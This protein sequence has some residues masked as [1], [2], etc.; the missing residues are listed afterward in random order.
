V[1]ALE[2]IG[3][4][5]LARIALAAMMAVTAAMVLH[6]TRGTAIWFDEWSWVLDR[7]GGGLGTLLEPHNG[8]FSLVPLLLYKALFATAGIDDYTP[9]RVMVVVGHLACGGLLYA[10]ARPRIGPFAA[11]LP[12]A[13]L[14]LL[15]PAWQN[16]LWP[17]Q[18]AW[19]ISLASG[20]GALLALD[21]DDRRGEIV[22]CVLLALA[23]ASS[24][25][26][27]AIAAG[28]LVE[29]VWRRRPAWVVAAPIAGYALWWIAYQD[30]DFFRHNVTV[31]P[32][33]AAEAAGGALA[34]VTGLSEARV[35][36]NGTLIDAGAALVWGR[37]LVLAAAAVLIWRLV[38]L[39]P[40]PVR[41][42]ALLAMAA[43]F[44]LLGGLQRA[45]IQSPDASRYLYVGA[46]FV[47]L[48]AVE[49][50]RG[51]RVGR[52]IAALAVVLTGLAV[53]SNVG[54]LRAGGRNLRAQADVT[55]ADL[56]ALV[57]ARDTVPP[58][59]HAAFIPGVPFVQIDAKEYFAAARELGSIA[60][61]PAELAAASEQGRLAA[62][63]ELANLGQL[64]PRPSSERPG[65][66]PPEVDATTGGT[67][68]T[69]AGCVLF[70]PAAATPAG[71]V[72]ELQV[73]VPTG[74]MLLTATGGRATV[75]L[76]RFAATFPRDP[77]ARLATGGSSVLR[78]GTDRATQPWHARLRP[79][80][81]VTVCGLRPGA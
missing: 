18:I 32:K 70:R 64:L 80:A 8:H 48:I 5:T 78:P 26:G 62:D 47:L 69:E 9:Y 36:V 61:S 30:T 49:L 75:A 79:E 22:A 71:T 33:F 59:Y 37:P 17:F 40:V 66:T 27:I 12:A 60:D 67:V 24:G 42:A 3:A 7:R 72:A 53:V 54:D 55:R 19:L 51:V 58:G 63:A 29:V 16:F 45:Q 41:L 20:L 31:A 76:R 25:I 35:D 81:G 14:L 21:R 15:G 2:R 43:T 74:G 11:L 38:A 39:R 10:Y 52:W 34:A 65:A 44:W 68:H 4:S 6:E 57:L 28:L 50:L 77:S 73:T 13:V 56:G 1:R 23:L 46:L